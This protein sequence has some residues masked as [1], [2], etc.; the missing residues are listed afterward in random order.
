MMGSEPAIGAVIAA[1]D[2]ARDQ[3]TTVTGGYLA[4][5]YFDRFQAVGVPANRLFLM[6]A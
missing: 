5:D 3:A 6:T 4:A 1:Q 2:G